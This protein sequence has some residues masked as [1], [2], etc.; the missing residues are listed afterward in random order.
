ML[1][2]LAISNYALIDTLEITFPE[3]LIIITGET[4]A[5]KSILLGAMSLLLGNRAEKE[6]L[7][8]D[9][10]NCVVEATFTFEPDSSTLELFNEFSIEPSSEIILRRVVTPN[11]KTR[12]F[13]NDQPIGVQ[14]L[15]IL[16]D[17]IIDIHAQHEHLLIGDSRFQMSVLDSYA[18]N[19]NELD[20][21]QSSYTLLKDLE[22][23]KELLSEKI[24]KDEQELEYNRF[25][26]NQLEEAKLVPGELEEL[27][28]EF[29]ILNNAEEIKNNIQ[30]AISCLNPNDISVVQG[31]RE[32]HTI[33]DKISQNLPAAQELAQRAEACRIELKDIES[34]LLLISEKIIVSPQ[35]A[36]QLDERIS[37]LY[38]LLRRYKAE[39]IENLIRIKEELAQNL[40]NTH[41]DQEKLEKLN[42]EIISAQSERERCAKAISK[43]RVDSSVGFASELRDKIREL[44]MPYAEFKVII[45]E[46]SNFHL[47]GK[48][49]VVF[50][51]SANKNIPPRELSK[52]A[53]GGELSRIMLC[54]KA[55]MA[56]ESGMPT[57]IFDEIDS[58]VSGSI[59]DK[60]GVLI[61]ELSQNMQV[62]AITHL[63]QIASKGG[64]HLLVYK[65]ADNTG[66]A[67]TKIKE[68]KKDQRVMEI[69]RML[70]GAG[71]TDAAVANAKVFLKT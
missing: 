45:T 54:L 58:G 20:S 25:Q 55:V 3:G 7:K 50:T 57:L 28:A 32:I 9:S 39:S 17:K 22:T 69:A 26:F 70:S 53:S 33:L 42:S 43:T 29:K 36:Q 41:N 60:M 2:S 13:I 14:F 1:R 19:K 12:S 40:L 23:E 64:C 61:D 18:K 4:G 66:K 71:L 21:Y 65:E 30:L 24:R 31:L 34:E 49:E 62:F 44:E 68:I 48:D 10:K 35:R 15:K 59:A 52:V 16:S 27:E 6:I 63:P 37:L 51:F 11:G 5:G 8:D 56:R 47:F 67:A 46:S 38:E